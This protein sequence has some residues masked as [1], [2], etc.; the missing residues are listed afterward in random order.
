LANQIVG[1][2]GI[3][4]NAVAPG[5]IITPLV[6]STFSRENISQ[7]NSGPMGRPGQPIEIAGTFPLVA[8]VIFALSSY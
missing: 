8:V 6:T 1:K 5:P 2:T 7:V 3:R 4:V